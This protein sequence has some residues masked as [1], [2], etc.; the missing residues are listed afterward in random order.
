MSVG[1]TGGGGYDSSVGEDGAVGGC[2]RVDAGS[3]SQRG[4]GGS[5]VR[6]LS[7]GCVSVGVGCGV[8][9]GAGDSVGGVVGTLSAGLVG[10]GR[11]AVAMSVITGRGVGSSV[12]SCPCKGVGECSGLGVG[13]RVAGASAVGP[14]GRSVKVGRGVARRVAVGSGS[15]VGSTTGGAVGSGMAVAIRVMI[16]IGDGTGVMEGLASTGDTDVGCIVGLIAGVWL[17]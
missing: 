3:G 15:D 5:L 11:K 9:V 2:A 4:A 7:E 17:L 6:S 12:G 1:G 8:S 14:S 16:A 13:L 10:P